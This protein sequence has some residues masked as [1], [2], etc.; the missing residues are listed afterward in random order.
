MQEWT[1]AVGIKQDF[2]PFFFFF[3]MY[4]QILWHCQ[5]AVFTI[6]EFEFF[7]NL[8]SILNFS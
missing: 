2:I 4:V 5:K 7:D 3:I 1:G 6:V 8:S